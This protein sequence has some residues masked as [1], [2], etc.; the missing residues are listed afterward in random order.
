M[1]QTSEVVFTEQV[2]AYGGTYCFPRK[3]LESLRHTVYDRP[4]TNRPAVVVT[5]GAGYIG[6]HAAL[7]FREAAYP[8]VVVDDLSTGRR[9]SLPED[10]LFIEG[11]AGDAEP[12]P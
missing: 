8:V 7:A 5:G 11:D 2:A 1:Q 12:T 4:M 10:V 9:D 6:S 3:G